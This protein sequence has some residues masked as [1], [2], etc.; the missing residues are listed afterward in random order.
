M[1]MNKTMTVTEAD[2]IKAILDMAKRSIN[3]L[4]DRL[5]K[6]VGDTRRRKEQLENALH[7]ATIEAGAMINTIVKG[8]DQHDRASIL[9]SWRMRFKEEQGVAEVNGRSER[10]QLRQD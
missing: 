2:K 5:V 7:D 3:S 9:A 6:D 10:C 8:V 1:S 4:Y